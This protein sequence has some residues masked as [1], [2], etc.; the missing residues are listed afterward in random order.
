[1][2]GLKFTCSKATFRSVGSGAVRWLD[3]EADFEMVQRFWPTKTP[4]K[5][6]EW[7]EFRDA[8][9]RYCAAVEDKQI[10]AVA[11]EYRFSDEAWMLAAVGTVEAYRRRGYGKQVCTFVTAHILKS[12]RIATCGTRE[13]NLPMIR[14]AESIGYS[15]S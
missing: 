3:W 7:Q 6:Q 11:A 9:Y 14:M 4:L 15:S 13:N 2:R 1:M 8:G 12:G 10:V 5:Q